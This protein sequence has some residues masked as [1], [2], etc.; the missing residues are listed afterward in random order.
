[1]LVKLF[2]SKAAWLKSK[3]VNKAD[4][5]TP[6]SKILRHSD[7]ESNELLVELFCLQF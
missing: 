7:H 5:P 6:D 4:C 1:M 3:A 2:A